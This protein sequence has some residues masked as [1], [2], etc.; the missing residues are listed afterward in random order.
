MMSD[1]DTS[2]TKPLRVLELMAE[3]EATRP[4]ATPESASA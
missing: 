1:M 3:I 2:M 4:A